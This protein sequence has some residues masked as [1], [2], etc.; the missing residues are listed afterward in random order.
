MFW[1]IFRV[2]LELT[3]KKERKKRKKKAQTNTESS[4]LFSGQN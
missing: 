3:G 4:V 2:K 1:K